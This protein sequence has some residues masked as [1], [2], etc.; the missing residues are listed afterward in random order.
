MSSVRPSSIGEFVVAMDY[1]Q[2]YLEVAEPTDGESGEDLMLSRAAGPGGV[3]QNRAAVLVESPHQ[4]NFKMSL[5][6]EEWT[7]PPDDDL[8]D[9]EEA[10]EASL[11]VGDYGLLFSSPTVEKVDL[12][13]PPGTYRALITGRGFVAV[14]WPGWTEP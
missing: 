1:S 14:G 2:F 8:D 11:V 12:E 3:A 6:V 9:W 10:L 5:R 13:V 4:N 7:D